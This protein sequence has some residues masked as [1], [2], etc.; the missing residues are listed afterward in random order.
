MSKND[1]P[2]TLR[3]RHRCDREDAILDVAVALMG[4]N[5]YAA[6]TMDDLAARAGISKPTL[7][8]HFDSKEVVA[9]RAVV[10]MLR[11]GQAFMDSLPDDLQ[12]LECFERTVRYMMTAKLVDCVS[13]LGTGRDALGPLIRAHP[14][15][16]SEYA[17]MMARMCAIID[18][19]KADGTVRTG[20]DTRATAQVAISLMRDTEYDD[21]IRCGACQS[22]AVVN[23]L[24]TIL[25]AGIRA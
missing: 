16:Q 13:Y 11:R 14:D 19:A 9:V 21:L 7:Y 20:L 18:A 12:P 15:Y 10:R 23:T 25:L 5:G 6:M 24:A 22:A 1:V 17:R 8:T 4:A 2:P 3:E